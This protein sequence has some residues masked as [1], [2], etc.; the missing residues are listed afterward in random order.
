MAEHPHAVEVVAGEG[1]LD[2]QDAVL[3]EL[4]DHPSRRLRVQPGRDVT[5]HPPPLV[6]IDHDLQRVPH[7]LADRGD[8]GDAGG[9]PVPGDP[10]LD[11]PEAVL[12]KRC[13]VLRALC[14]RAQLAEG[15]VHREPVDRAAEQRGHRRVE[16]VSGQIPQRRLQGPVAAGVKR[17]R[18]QG[19]GVGGE[20]Q[21]V[22]A[23][24]QVLERLEPV[25]RV[26]AGDARDAL[27]GVDAHERR[28][29]PG[30]GIRVPGRVEGG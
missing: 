10:D 7:R 20:R 28:I 16:R 5:G 3:G 17:D 19:A 24:E 18:L 4:V 26:A 2:P 25:H 14:R 29:E 30:P 23:D 22:T 27:V 9:E 21:G 6:E 12:D 1:L 11:R 8:D 13:G 15:G